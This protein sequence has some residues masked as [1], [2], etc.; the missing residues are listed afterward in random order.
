MSYVPSP[1]PF[2]I[3]T[4]RQHFRTC[5]TAY[6]NIL[7]WKDAGGGLKTIKFP[8]MQIKRDA[9]G[10]AVTGV[11]LRRKND[12]SAAILLSFPA[13][14][15]VENLADPPGAFEALVTNGGEFNV[16]ENVDGNFYYLEVIS[17]GVSYYS[18]AFYFVEGRAD[19]LFPKCGD[20][21]RIRWYDPCT[22]SETIWGGGDGFQ[23]L[24]DSVPARPSFTYEEEGEA[25]ADGSFQPSFRRLQK[26]R[27]LE[28]FAPEWI[29][30]AMASAALFNSV[31][32][33]Y[34]DG[35]ILSG[36]NGIRTE[37]EWQAGGCLARFTWIFKYDF[38]TR[39]GCC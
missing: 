29:A 39:Q 32:L 22:I 12:T 19:L 6:K 10:G 36:I 35:E 14:W 21:V 7:L 5:G 37:L 34:P 38:L 27:K 33:E 25:D 26:E 24:I 28:L 3:S 13:A 11:T 2:H 9:G 16:T 20:V 23:I 4:D 18:E 17:D 30:E 8:P 31:S 1:I 15:S